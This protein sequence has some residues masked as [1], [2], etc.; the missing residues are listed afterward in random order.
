VLRFAK[1]WPAIAC[2]ITG[3]AL[4]VT[5]GVL[6]QMVTPQGLVRYAMLPPWLALLGFTC[7]AGLLLL[8]L[9][10]LNAPRGTSA[11]KRPRLGELVLP[12]L[13]LVILIVPFLPFLPDSWP[14]VQAL[15]GPLAAV[16]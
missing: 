3:A 14:V 1:L 10:H 8:G 16:V 7:L 4:Y 9:D 2:A 6:D 12:T 11:N 13:A 15:A 5:R